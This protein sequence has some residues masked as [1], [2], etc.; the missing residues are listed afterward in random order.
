MKLWKC[1]I[2]DKYQKNRVLKGKPRDYQVS[3]GGQPSN[4]PVQ[5][6]VYVNVYWATS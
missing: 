6:V 2:M 1:H 4:I 3:S 5:E